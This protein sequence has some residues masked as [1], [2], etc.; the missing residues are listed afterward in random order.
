M[1]NNT[2]S[3]WI[4]LTLLAICAAQASAAQYPDRLVWVFGWNLNRESDVAD[5]TRVLETAA[6]H[7][8]NGAVLS[9]GLDTFSRRTPDYFDRLEQVKKTCDSLNIELIPGVFSIGYAGSLPGVNRNPA[10][11]LP[12]LVKAW[13]E[14]AAAMD[15]VRG[16]MYT[17]WQKK[18]ELLGEFGDLIKAQQ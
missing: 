8:I 1:N 9:A 12:V 4:T 5:I 14:L 10:E 18:Y 3:R 6:K 16:F 7:G 15:N 17:P 11:G 13:M 2:A